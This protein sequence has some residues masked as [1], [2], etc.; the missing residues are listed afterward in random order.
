MCKNLTLDTGVRLT[1][2]EE[3]VAEQEVQITALVTS[4]TNQNERMM[5]LENE[6][7]L[8]VDRIVALETVDTDVQQRLGDLE[9]IILGENSAQVNIFVRMSYQYFDKFSYVDIQTFIGCAVIELIIFYQEFTK[10][11][12][13]FGMML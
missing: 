6:V 12:Q 13:L 9:E 11:F 5:I 10:K 7:D 8:W 1:A 2:V 4:D 3:A